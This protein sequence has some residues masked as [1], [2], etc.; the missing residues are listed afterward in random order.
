MPMK[1]PMRTQPQK[2]TREM[3]AVGLLAGDQSEMGAM[4]LRARRSSN[5]AAVRK[6]RKSAARE[7]D[8]ELDKHSVCGLA[9]SEF[10]LLPHDCLPR[11]SVPS[12]QF[13]VPV[14]CCR[15]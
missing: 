4:E 11:L 1:Q 5:F 2:T 9:K 13:S 15:L 7:E 14:F 3:S 8:G 12:C 6:R 10:D